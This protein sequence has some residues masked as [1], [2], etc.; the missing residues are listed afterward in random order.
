MHI[1]PRSYDAPASARPADQ[2]GRAPAWRTGVGSPKAPLERG[3]EGGL[4]QMADEVVH[5][6]V[7]AVINRLS[8]A[9]AAAAIVWLLI[10]AAYLW[11]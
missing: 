8:V 4:G 7:V 6:F 2:I 9:L 10:L 5:W 3:L 1:E 11:A